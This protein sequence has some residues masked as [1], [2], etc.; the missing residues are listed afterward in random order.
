MG[1]DFSHGCFRMSYGGFAALLADL[2]A[3]AGIVVAK[4]EGYGGNRSWDEI[5]D[6]L[7]PL[8]I[9][10]DE[11]GGGSLTPRQSLEAKRRIRELAGRWSEGR[12]GR[13]H[14]FK[15]HAFRLAECMSEAAFL[16]ERFEWF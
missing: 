3:E 2:A 6:P 8:F 10:R 11:Y 15:G 4:M 16:G 7:K 14:S 5:D 1:V 12:K 9:N 13:P